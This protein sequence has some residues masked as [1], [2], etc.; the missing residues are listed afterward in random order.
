MRSFVFVRKNAS[1]QQELPYN[2]DM[3]FIIII[4]VLVWLLISYNG[5]PYC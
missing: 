3:L 1:T 5:K 4:I 2:M